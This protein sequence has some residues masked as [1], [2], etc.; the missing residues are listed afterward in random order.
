V[1]RLYLLDYEGPG[2][3]LHAEGLLEAEVLSG[4][5]VPA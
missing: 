3:E 5:V 4:E 2:V 1:E